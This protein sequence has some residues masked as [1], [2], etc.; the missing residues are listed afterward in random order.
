MQFLKHHLEI[1]IIFLKE[2][3]GFIIIFQASY[4]FNVEDHRDQAFIHA[5]NKEL[6]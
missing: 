6:K 3:Y 4:I 1:F 5:L 2:K